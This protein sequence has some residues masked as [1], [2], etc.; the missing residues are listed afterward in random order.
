MYQFLEKDDQ[1]LVTDDLKDFT[2]SIEQSENDDSGFSS[3]LHLSLELLHNQGSDA[4]VCCDFKN[5]SVSKIIINHK[6]SIV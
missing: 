4:S 2:V 1:F 6:R 5:I 3:S